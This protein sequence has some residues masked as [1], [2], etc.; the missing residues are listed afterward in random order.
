MSANCHKVLRRKVNVAYLVS[1]RWWLTPDIIFIFIL[2][3]P[4]VFLRRCIRTEIYLEFHLCF[5][6]YNFILQN[7]SF[8]LNDIMF[9]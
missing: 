1:R 5:C 7:Y 4:N 9:P 2:S 8:Q 3:T 6:I